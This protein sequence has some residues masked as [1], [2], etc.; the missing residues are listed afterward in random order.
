M[1]NN[2]TLTLI[3]L[4][5]SVEEIFVVVSTNAVQYDEIVFYKKVDGDKVK[6]GRG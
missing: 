1:N 5:V 4:R 2:D 6:I 3:N